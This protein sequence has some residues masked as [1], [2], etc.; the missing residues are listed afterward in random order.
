[1]AWFMMKPHQLLGFE[2]HH[3]VGAAVVIAELNFVHSRRPGFNNRAD[4]PA[5]KTFVGEIFQQCD[6]GIKL[7]LCHRSS[8]CST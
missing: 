1:M 2:C 7:D 6:H 3:G 4:L 5:N 8:P